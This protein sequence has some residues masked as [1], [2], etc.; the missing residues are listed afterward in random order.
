MADS[1]I[2]SPNSLPKS[3]AADPV[4]GMVMQSNTDYN[5][6]ADDISN[7]QKQALAPINK[8]ISTGTKDL[9]EMA[10]KGPDTVPLPENKAQHMSPESMS[11]AFSTFLTLGALGGLLTRQPMTAALN[12]MTA[13]MKGLHDGDE[14]QYKRATDEFNNNF[15]K[16]TAANKAKMDE[17]NRVFSAK[18][19]TVAEKIREAGDIAKQY[20]DELNSLN[21]K[22]GNLKDAF[23]NMEASQKMAFEAQ[24]HV[25]TMRKFDQ[26]RSERAAEHAATLAETHRFHESEV[27]H[28]KDE[29]IIS[30]ER[31]ESYKNHVNAV[32]SSGKQMNPS[33]KKS[34]E[35]DIKEIDFALDALQKMKTKTGS[36]FLAQDKPGVLNSLLGK[37]ATPEEMQAYDK[38]AN[39]LSVA[40]AS[41]QSMGRGQISD[42]KVRE[43]R[44][45]IP[46]LGDKPE[47]IKASWDMIKNIR[48]QADEVL[49]NEGLPGPDAGSSFSTEAEAEAA[50]ASGKLKS[51]T[52]VTIGGQSGVWQ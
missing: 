41:I 2:L 16:A 7:R 35:L 12:N 39:R 45:L 33:M 50:A 27:Q 20:G 6:A 52:R 19:K 40:I 26:D 49:K 23:K 9:S 42:A 14:E 3:I 4:M 18:D 1:N 37:S 25:D 48:N 11:K 44:K 8:E 22:A 51:G 38:Y 31:A 10:S 24:K 29:G 46:Q 21:F 32:K 34:V 47:S 17:Y 43:A 13:A 15:T 30:K 28:W 36:P 5:R